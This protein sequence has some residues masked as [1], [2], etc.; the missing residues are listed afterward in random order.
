MKKNLKRLIV[1]SGLIVSLAACSSGG[2]SSS[3]GSGGSQGDASKLTFVAPNIVPSLPVASTSYLVVNNP[4][5]SLISGVQYK[6]GAFVGGGSKVTLEP[7]SA[8]NC[9]KIAANSSCSIKLITPAYTTAGSFNVS[10]SNNATLLNNLATKANGRNKSLA[11]NLPTT[12][13]IGVEQVLYTTTTGANGV[14]LYYFNTVVAGV[15]MIMVTG[16]VN[17]SQVGNLNTVT[18]IGPDNTP[19]P[20]QQVISGNMGAGAPSL[21]MGSTFN[22]LLPAPTGANATQTIKVQTEQI[23]SNGTVSNTQISS[24]SSTLT[25]TTGVAI[26]DMLPSSIYLTESNPSQQITFS[27]TG[28]VAAQLQSLVASNS[29]IEV[30]FSS[31]SVAPGG[32]ATATL[33]LKDPSVPAASSS[34]TLSYNNGKTDVEQS[35]S[36]DQNVVPGP[37]PVPVP[38]PGPTPVAGLTA[39][40]ANNNFNVTTVKH[41]TFESMTITN[42]G[43][44]TESN[45]VVTMPNNNFSLVDNAGSANDCKVTSG[46]IDLT[47]ALES[48]T[49]CV[50]TVKYDNNTVTSGS[51]NISITYNYGTGTPAP[52]AATAAV[53]WNVAQST[54]NLSI[55]GD[56]ANPYIYPTTLSDGSGESNTM[57]FTIKNTGEVAATGISSV[58]NSTTLAGLFASNNTAS[59][60]ACSDTL[61]PDATCQIGVQFGPIPDNTSAGTKNGDLTISY[62]EFEAATTDSTIVQ[63]LQGQVATSGSAVFN[64]PQ[65]GTASG[66]TDNT[67]A[68]LSIN[69]NTTNGVITYTLTNTGADAA[70]NFIVTLPSAPTGWTNIATTCPTTT[71]TNLA[72]QANCNITLTADTTT[73]GTI[74]ATNFTL[75]LAWSDQD[76][77][78]GDTQN[79]QIDTPAVTVIALPSAQFET[80]TTGTATGF[81][82]NTWSSLTIDQ[83]VFTGTITYTLTNTGTGSA[84]NFYVTMD[85]IP[86]GWFF[87]YE[88]TTCPLSGSGDIAFL[89]PKD[90][91]NIVLA[92]STR[93]SGTISASNLAIT[94]NW[95]DKLN[96]DGTSQSMQIATPAVTV[97]GFYLFK[98]PKEIVLNSAGTYAFITDS[99]NKVISCSIDNGTLSNCADSGATGLN[100]PNGITL[101]SAGTYAFITNLGNS[102][103]TQCSVSNGTLS[104]C[105]NSGATGLLIPRAIALNSDS[106]Y[107]FITNT[108]STITQC[109]VDNGTL[110]KCTNSGATKL[111]NPGGITLNPAGT[112]AF[113][114]NSDAGTV[115]Q[116]SVNNGTL[117]NCA[118]SGATSLSV[119]FGITLNP[120]GTQAFITN[121]NINLVTQCSV[122]NGT[123]SNCANSG[124]KQLGAPYG[125]TL[126]PAGTYAFITNN[127][128]STITQCSVNN[129]TLSNC[130][131]TGFQ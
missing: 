57:I 4:T 76:S 16:V 24:N 26:V 117:F 100:I 5:E 56:V 102:T 123:L 1:T 6:L 112:Y 62:K 40:L 87:D 17:S 119:P 90:S 69:Q 55:T 110:S 130:A 33:R 116:C 113:I 47:Q 32:K 30:V 88:V 59:T 36:V 51:G 120:T 68:S 98:G 9:A 70:T 39:I 73:A 80:P 66:F 61:A 97:I 81:S 129:G 34:I 99:S 2:S 3:D 94:L 72:P 128:D 85:S 8:A 7:T 19:I 38:P 104:N 29:N 126:N 118:D 83:Y 105:V 101:N 15:P 77:P 49:N 65:T 50:V 22:I 124:A 109:S 18:L 106:T 108:N 25:T 64:A 58:V 115:T 44:T 127:G 78:S 84:E 43:N 45:F 46:A 20:G 23:A 53:N 93:N 82:N 52:S 48:S 122:N 35:S 41:T 95:D 71:G 60:P 67:W 11:A 37:D 96:P 31:T 121:P 54:A 21:T 63:N 74:A 27:N 13:T 114:T 91:C 131:Q 14:T 111:N 89:D 107:A 103:V 86:T 28:D 92:P 42:T 10:A 79:M 75:G 12:P 125:I